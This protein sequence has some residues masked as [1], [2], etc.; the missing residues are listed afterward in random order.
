[1]D[2]S[3]FRLRAWARGVVAKRRDRPYRAGRTGDWL[4]IE[5]VRRDSFIVVGYEAGSHG[6]ISKLLLAGRKGQDAL[7][8]VGSVG[9][10]LSEAETFSTRSR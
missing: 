9:T 3:S 1:M 6:G 4:K 10:G 7:V 5:C 2:R 8:Y